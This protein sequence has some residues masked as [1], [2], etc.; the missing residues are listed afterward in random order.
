MLHQMIQIPIITI[1]C[2]VA[3][4]SGKNNYSINDIYFSRNNTHDTFPTGQAIFSLG[5]H[6]IL[7]LLSFFLYQRIHEYA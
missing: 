6:Q 3:D 1:S 4:R 5:D 2:D 7:A